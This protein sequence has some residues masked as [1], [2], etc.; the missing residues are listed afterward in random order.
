MN[1][2]LLLDV[3]VYRCVMFLVQVCI[4]VVMYIPIQCTG[5]ICVANALSDL[6]CVLCR[7]WR[8]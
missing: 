3:L 2:L 5:T 6:V 8:M 4:C 7:L 1:L